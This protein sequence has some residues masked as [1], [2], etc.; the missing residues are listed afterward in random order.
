MFILCLLII[1]SNCAEYFN[2]V[3]EMFLINFSP[4]SHTTKQQRIEGQPCQNNTQYIMFAM[5]WPFAWLH[6]ISQETHGAHCSERYLSV[7]VNRK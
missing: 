2:Y 6:K 7:P 1:K 3:R 5:L 4:P